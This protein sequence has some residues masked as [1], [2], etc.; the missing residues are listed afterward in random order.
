MY[1]YIAD[2]YRTE[3]KMNYLKLFT[4]HSLFCKLSEDTLRLVIKSL[5]KE[6]Y[7]PNDI[8]IK[9]GGVAHYLYFILHGTVAV[10]TPLGKE[11]NTH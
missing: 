10:L 5:Q 9:S 3:I 8:V 4:D 7:L 6:V 1:G 2:R 11:V